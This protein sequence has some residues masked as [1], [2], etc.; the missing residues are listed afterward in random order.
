MR[1]LASMVRRGHGGCACSVV[2]AMTAFSVQC[3][4]PLPERTASAD[5]L[6]EELLVLERSALDRWIRLD[7]DGY[8]G[9]FAPEATYFDP[10]TERRIVGLA[11][12]QRRL[13]PIKQ[14]KAPFSEPRYE[15]IEPRVQHHGDVAL[16]TFNLNNYGKLADG[17]E[18]LLARWN[19]SEVYGQVDG[20]W[21]IIHS[22]WSYVQPQLKQ[23]GSQ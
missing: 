21:K 23:A 2:I 12:M 13:A 15:F 19:S 20:K 5:S 4:T 18:H 9:L 11:A 3:T 17:A 7:P 14:M 6:L 16:L 22:H 10:R 1:S 8:L